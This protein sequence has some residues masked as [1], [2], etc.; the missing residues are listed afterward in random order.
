[1]CPKGLWPSAQRFNPGKNT[2]RFRPEGAADPDLAITGMETRSDAILI[3]GEVDLILLRAII[4]AKHRYE[5]RHLICRPFQ[6]ETLNW[7][8]P[9]VKTL[10]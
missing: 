5:V 2:I 7:T 9:R 10:G 8:V 1:M 3:A 6:G 4:L